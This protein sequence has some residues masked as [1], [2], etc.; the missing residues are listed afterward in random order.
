MIFYKPVLNLAVISLVLIAAASTMAHE[1]KRTE[2]VVNDGQI[3]GQGYL[4]A[5]DGNPSDDF[6]GITRPYFNAIH[7]H[8]VP[9]GSFGVFTNVTGFD[10]REA[11]PF[12]GSDIILTLTGAGKWESPPAADGTMLEQD[13][14]TP[15]LSPLSDTE[16]IE[17][18]ALFG[19]NPTISTNSPGSFTLVDSVSGPS[20]D[21]D[22]NP[23][24][25]FDP[26][27][28]LYYLQ[29]Q[30]S[31]PG[32]GLTPSEPLYTILSPPGATGIER[33]HFQSLALERNFGI[34]AAAVP[35]PGALALLSLAGIAALARRRASRQS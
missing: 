2:I 10:L 19:S 34:S 27:G 20:T 17:I 21:I 3:F 29:W 4:F 13:F 25:D 16:N 9:V 30:L 28:S 32:S 24:I 18:T 11:D 31:A 33:L 23:N 35:E 1:G 22:L 12:L 26:T 6:G 8:F 7:S 5:S 14:G 15:N